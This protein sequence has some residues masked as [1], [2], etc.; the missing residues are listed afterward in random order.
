MISLLIL[1]PAAIFKACQDK[2]LFHF[3]TSVFSQL[4]N[5]FFWDS[6]L[7]WYNKYKNNDPKQGEKFL[8]SS[9]VF[10]F[11]T[12]GFHLTQML[13][14]TSMFLA[15][16]L[17]KPMINWWVDFIIMRFLFGAIFEIFFKYLLEKKK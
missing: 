10:V 12:D 16:I 8:G 17:Y 7:S 2:I 6:K 13:F 4:K 1:I 14:L 9:G 11:V 15:I 3:Y 5:Q